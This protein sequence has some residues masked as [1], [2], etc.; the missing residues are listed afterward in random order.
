MKLQNGCQSSEQAR[1][2]VDVVVMAALEK[3]LAGVSSWI[4]ASGSL[5]FVGSLPGGFYVQPLASVVTARIEA[6]LTGQ[7]LSSRRYSGRASSPALLGLFNVALDA[8]LP[9]RRSFSSK[10][11]SPS[12]SFRFLQR[13]KPPLAS[14]HIHLNFGVELLVLQMIDPLAFAVNIPFNRTIW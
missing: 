9:D 13:A 1:A 2:V 3:A 4:G 6:C 10:C 12:C 11:S 7:P 14:T 5:D 8:S